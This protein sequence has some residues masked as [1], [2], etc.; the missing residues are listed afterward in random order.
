[1]RAPN[2][3]ELILPPVPETDIGQH[4]TVAPNAINEPQTE[5]RG[6]IR[7]AS[8]LLVTT[9]LAGLTPAAGASAEHHDSETARAATAASSTYT[10]N[11]MRP[12]AYERPNSI[13][14]GSVIIQAPRSTRTTRKLQ[15][16]STVES[17]GVLIAQQ[18]GISTN[19]VAQGKK[20]E[21]TIAD[22]RIDLA[23]YRTGT[24]KAEA[25]NKSKD[26][27]WNW[28]KQDIVIAGKAAG[29]AADKIKQTANDPKNIKR[30]MQGYFEDNTNLRNDPRHFLTTGT[31]YVAKHARAEADE[32]VGAMRAAKDTQ[33]PNPDTQA[34]A[35]PDYKP[36]HAAPEAAPAPTKWERFKKVA[37]PV[38]KLGGM[39][40]G[41]VI[42]V[43]GA[44]AGVGRLRRRR[45]DD[46]GGDTTPTGKHHHSPNPDGGLPLP[47][48]DFSDLRKIT[49]KDKENGHDPIDPPTGTHAAGG[50]GRSPF[51]PRPSEK[52]PG[53]KSTESAPTDI[54]ARFGKPRLIDAPITE[55]HL[56]SVRTN[57]TRSDTAAS[58]RRAFAQAEVPE[59]AN[60]KDAL[61]DPAAAPVIPLN[62]RRPLEGRGKQPDGTYIGIHRSAEPVVARVPLHRPAYAA[63]A[64][65]ISVAA[66]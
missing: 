29:L 9:A 48:D 46:G 66:V 26:C 12:V 51:A 4:R 57:N 18:M 17:D 20:T 64:T 33:K 32:L 15:E 63:A 43:A 5:R 50:L 35:Q 40:L 14:S 28:A 6:S 62:G 13:Y 24:R 59:P 10:A 61:T 37:A 25:W 60:I 54:R 56:R 58:I 52:V 3:A 55:R 47:P 27:A 39:A 11:N 19:Q 41:G 36:R 34:Q 22:V 42:L 1:M 31:G 30:V 8:T 2:Q 21:V 65:D 53:E 49:E 45:R 7:I 38:M 16:P 44:I 23:D